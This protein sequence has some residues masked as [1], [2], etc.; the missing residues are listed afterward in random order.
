MILKNTQNTPFST[1]NRQQ[2]SSTKLNFSLSDWIRFKRG[3]CP[4][5]NGAKKD[6]RQNQKTTLI[7]CRDISA[8]PLDYVFRGQDALGFGMWIYKPN[9]QQW[10]QERREQWQRERQ[11]DQSRRLAHH[12]KTALP[13]ESIDLAIRKLAR[14]LGLTSEHRQQ[15]RDRGLTDEQIEKGLFFS[16]AENQ[17]IPPGIPPN[18]P[19]VDW[20][21]QKLFTPSP[22]IACPAFNAEGKA[23]GYQIR[24][25]EADSG[26]YRWPK[27]QV[28]SHLQNGELPL[29]VTGPSL[30]NT[31]VV[32]LPEGILKP[33]VA[34]QKWGIP[35]IGAAGGNHR[36]SSEQL[37]ESLELLPD[38]CL[39]AIA[40]DAGA[41]LN[42]NVLRQY[43]KTVKLL[44]DWGY[45]DRIK[46]VW[47]GQTTKSDHDCDEITQDEFDQIQYLTPD[48]FLQIANKEQWKKKCWDRWE[49]SKQFTPDIV[50]RDR[51]FSYPV[52]QHA[53]TIELVKGGL[54]GGKSTQIREQL[55]KYWKEK[56]VISLGYRNI[57]LLQFG[58]HEQLEGCNFTHIHQHSSNVYFADP[59]LWLTSCIDS[60][61]KIPLESFDSKLLILDEIVS[62]IKHL[63]FSS[64]IKNRPLVIKHFFEAVRRCD[65]VVGLD[66][67]M[68]D[69][70]GDF[71]QGINSDKKIIKIENQYETPKAPLTILLGTV[72]DDEKLCPNDRSP[73]LKQLLAEVEPTAVDADSQ[74]L[75][76][77]LDKRL[78]AQG[79]KTLRID[80]KTVTDKTL[81]ITQI[82]KKGINRYLR[83]NNIDVLLYSPS[84]ESGLDVSITDYFKS[85]YSFFY[86]VLDV[87]SSLQMLE[88]I[89][90]VKC[91]KYIWIRNFSIVDEPNE[92]KSYDAEIIA[93]YQ[94][95]S[96]TR[97]LHS[98]MAGEVDGLEAMANILKM[99][100]DSHGP[101][102]KTANQLQAIRN[103]ERANFRECFTRMLTMKGYVFD[104][105]TCNKNDPTN[106]A[107][108]EEIKAATNEVKDQNAHDI[109][110]ASD[111]FIGRTHTV[112]RFDA[113]WATRC[114]L[115]KARWIDRLPGIEKT[116]VWEQSLI[117]L[118]KYDKPDLVP[119]LERYYL[120]SNLD[121]AKLLGVSRYKKLN[122]L[123]IADSTIC[124]WQLTNKYSSL[125]ASVDIGILNLLEH[126][127]ERFTIDHPMI[128]ATLSKAQT[129]PIQ[130]ALKQ[131]IG[132]NPMK[133]I[134]NQVRSFGGIWQRFTEKINGKTSH[135][136]KAIAPIQNPI[137]Q[138][139]FLAIERKIDREI[140]KNNADFLKKSNCQNNDFSSPETGSTNEFE[141]V[142]LCRTF[143][144]KNTPQVEPLTN[145]DNFISINVKTDPMDMDNDP[146]TNYQEGDRVML[147]H[148][149]NGQWQ[150]ATIQR[151][152]SGFNGCVYV[153]ADNGMGNWITRHQLNQLAPP[154]VNSNK[155]EVC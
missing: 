67:N 20:S 93:W 77:S 155:W 57:L 131:K 151:V 26:K 153:L 147:W 44:T 89:R 117:R 32:W 2:Q 49:K 148:S 74:I 83:E 80:S 138:E 97:D 73:A 30:T 95:Q 47:Y 121:K 152:V 126:P 24:L 144:I 59:S 70:V 23:I 7:H 79:K 34:S 113:D 55:L 45:G 111:Q 63:L 9:A 1:P 36:S 56:G 18:F 133:F 103:F 100:Q 106:F 53:K 5:C 114:A 129:K 143:S 123:A 145:P 107:A 136:Y 154:L 65:R 69:W 82:L 68:A 51:Y 38:D 130:H 98:V 118:I 66:G 4:V 42:Q 110:T 22:G 101:D 96:L 3:N 132:K 14:Y 112:L 149:F 39:I 120:A 6:C 139:I 52:A 40:P 37:K 76:E 125:K 46:F 146:F 27:G 116:E 92:S 61:L 10:N 105:V 62:I 8:N 11:A 94:N 119:S 25:T 54:G 81:N 78:T 15:L 104:E 58:E 41:I 33:Y 88:R 35:C 86:G 127:E 124:P 85:H 109:F 135:Y 102:S 91:P 50:T 29:T 150:P 17:E 122:E 84:A 21:E 48:K 16:I 43:E 90:D 75:L 31:T 128:K 12:A 28:S 71:F 60:I 13:V 115:E 137:T 99:V 134:G 72:G 64:T 142:P 108:K 19:G 87:D 141:Q 140:L